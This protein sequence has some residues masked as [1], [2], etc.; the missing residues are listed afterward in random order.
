MIFAV[1]QSKQKGYLWAMSWE[2]LKL[3]GYDVDFS[4]ALKK[5]N[6]EEMVCG[7]S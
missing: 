5:W 6:W 1:N 2:E 7:G 3:T 4:R